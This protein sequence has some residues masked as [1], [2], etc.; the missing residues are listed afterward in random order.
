MKKTVIGLLLA[1]GA[2]TAISCKKDYYCECSRVYT[3]NNSTAS[4]KDDVYTFN[5]TRARAETKCN[6]QEKTGTDLFGGNYS[7]ECQIK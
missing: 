2:T 5:D 1:I 4:Y 6:D 3:S 7:K